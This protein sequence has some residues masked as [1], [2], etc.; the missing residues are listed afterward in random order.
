MK[1]GVSNLIYTIS[2]TARTLLT[3][4]RNNVHSYPPIPS[5][6]LSG[7]LIIS[8][9]MA[10]TCPGCGRPFSGLKGLATHRNR[11]CTGMP[12]LVSWVDKRNDDRDDEQSSS[13]R[14]R[15]YIGTEDVMLVDERMSDLGDNAQSELLPEPLSVPQTPPSPVSVSIS[16]RKRKVP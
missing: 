8:V 11:Y 9:A 7:H 16:G 10:T 12:R 15:N 2:A 13:K 3:L 14:A 1:C 6:T 4:A 5:A